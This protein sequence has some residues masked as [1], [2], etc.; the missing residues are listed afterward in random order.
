MCR[1]SLARVA[2]SREVNWEHFT[3]ISIWSSPR[4][5]RTTCNHHLTQLQPATE[6]RDALNWLEQRVSAMTLLEVEANS[7]ARYATFWPRYLAIDM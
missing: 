3:P 6:Q 2:V 1:L 5:T 4:P 7:R